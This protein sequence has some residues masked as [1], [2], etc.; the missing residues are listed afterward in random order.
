[1]SIAFELKQG[2]SCLF[3]KYQTYSKGLSLSDNHPCNMILAH[4]LRFINVHLR[5]LLTLC[6]SDTCRTNWQTIPFIC[7]VSHALL[8]CHSGDDPYMKFHPIFEIYLIMFAPD[9][10]SFLKVGSQT[11]LNDRKILR[12]QPQNLTLTVFRPQWPYTRR[13]KIFWK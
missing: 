6:K 4:T 1:M 12:L 3:T 13:T 10:I 9:I 2:L 11:F 5:F 8:I 7:I